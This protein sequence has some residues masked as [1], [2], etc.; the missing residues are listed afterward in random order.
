MLML[1]ML[2]SSGGETR[3]RPC[4]SYEIPG[5]GVSQRGGGAA[6]HRLQRAHL[7]RPRAARARR[8]LY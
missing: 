3:E 6:R 7:R 4:G 1:S 2:S 5:G 8:Y